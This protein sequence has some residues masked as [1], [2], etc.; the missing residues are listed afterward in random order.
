MDWIGLDNENIG[1]TTNHLFWTQNICLNNLPMSF[2][3]FFIFFLIVGQSRLREIFLKT[4]D[5]IG[6]RYLAEMTREVSWAEFSSVK[7][8]WLLFQTLILSS[9]LCVLYLSSILLTIHREGT[10]HTIILYH[11]ILNYID[12]NINID[13]SISHTVGD[14]WLG[15]E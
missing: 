5:H 1:S 9:Y 12:V 2:R 11:I 3:L 4:E 6:G 14:G 7:L 8:I 13:I 15:G 10:C